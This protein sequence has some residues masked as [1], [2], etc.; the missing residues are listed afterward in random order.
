VEELP[1]IWTDRSAGTSRF[2]LFKWL[3]SYLHWYFW[4]LR[5]RWLG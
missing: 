3:P 1:A 4:A 2:R 5:K